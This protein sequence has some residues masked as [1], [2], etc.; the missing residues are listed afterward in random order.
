MRDTSKPPIIA[1]IIPADGGN[2]EAMD[3]PKHNGKAIR[4]TRNPDCKSL[5]Q[6]SFKPARPVWGIV[7]KDGLFIIVLVEVV[8]FF[9]FG[10]KIL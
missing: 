5:R 3:T 6:F 9:L 7:E 2:P 4:K 8:F 1:V 10:A